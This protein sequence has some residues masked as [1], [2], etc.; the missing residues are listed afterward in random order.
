MITNFNKYQLYENLSQLD[1]ISSINEQLYNN[2]E[3]TPELIK[4]LKP[5]EVFV[6]GSNRQGI[7]GGGAAA[8]AR[9]SFGAQEGVASGMTGQ[10]YAIYTKDYD[11]NVKNDNAKSVPLWEIRKQIMELYKFAKKNPEM[12]FLVTKI[13]SALAGYSIDEI[14]LCF[15][16]IWG[17]VP[18]NVI[19]PIEFVD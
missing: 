17:T 12:K 14:K 10:C 13:G 9:D 19:L 5:N 1:N 11:V 18:T 16:S 15:T 3:Y 6:F 8:Y 2:T 7:L 4:F